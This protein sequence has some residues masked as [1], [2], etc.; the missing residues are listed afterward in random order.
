VIINLSDD[1]RNLREDI[2]GEL[3]AINDYQDHIDL[4]EDDEVREVLAH[5][6]D[7]EKEHVAELVRLLRKLDPEQEARFREE[8]S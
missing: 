4:A 2:R 8:E 1:L 3:S 5:I 7:E 6:R